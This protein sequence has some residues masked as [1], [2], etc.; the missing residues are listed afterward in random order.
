M[1]VKRVERGLA[2]SLASQLPDELGELAVAIG[3]QVR[4]FRSQKD[5]TAVDCAKQANLSAAML[6]KIENG[7]A[8]P[9]LATLHS[10][11][12]ALDV[13]LTA[14]FKRFEEQSVVCYTPAGKGSVSYTHQ[15][16]P[17]LLLV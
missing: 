5:M 7:N 10:L 13:P 4:S 8:S 15:T 16:L 11:S 9:S 1:G 6:S 2:Q 12:R 17:T 14:F 3:H